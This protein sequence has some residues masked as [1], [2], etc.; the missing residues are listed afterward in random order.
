MYLCDTD[1]CVGYD[2]TDAAV[3][4]SSLCLVFHIYLE[5]A[6]GMFELV[7]SEDPPVH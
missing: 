4:I 6:F 7:T 1:T 5:A 3:H 2:V